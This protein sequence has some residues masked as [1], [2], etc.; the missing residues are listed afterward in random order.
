MPPPLLCLY[1]Q[2]ALWSAGEIKRAPSSKVKSSHDNCTWIL[3]LQQQCGPPALQFCRTSSLLSAHWP[4]AA[5]WQP[6]FMLCLQC[7]LTSAASLII[8]QELHP[9]CRIP[10]CRIIFVEYMM[11]GGG[12]NKTDAL[13]ISFSRYSHLYFF[14][15]L[16]GEGFLCHFHIESL[17]FLVNCYHT[18]YH[19]SVAHGL[20]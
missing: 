18:V 7:R 10:P 3:L 16:D 1:F 14:T 13:K 17:I 12:N 20:P 5:D 15:F 4:A 2:R 11:L 9:V 19:T 8:L 6:A